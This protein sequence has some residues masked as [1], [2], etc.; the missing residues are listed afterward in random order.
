MSLDPNSV[1][2]TFST[3]A[4]TIAAIVVISLMI[5]TFTFVYLKEKK[6]KR[7]SKMGRRIFL[8]VIWV[9]TLLSAIIAWTFLYPSQEFSIILFFILFLMAFSMVIS[10]LVYENAFKP[11]SIILMLLALLFFGGAMYAGCYTIFIIFSKMVLV[12]N[13]GEGDIWGIIRFSRL[14]ITFLLIAS[15]YLAGFVAYHKILLES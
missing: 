9:I 4:Q 14:F 7:Y 15:L 2:F 1:L 5:F 3:I 12:P 10:Y 13:I 11:L 8:I 6:A